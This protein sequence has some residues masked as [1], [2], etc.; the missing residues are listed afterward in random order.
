MTGLLAELE[1]YMILLF[2]EWEF[3]NILH[4]TNAN[5]QGECS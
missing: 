4:I 3:M 5:N 1:M 2:R